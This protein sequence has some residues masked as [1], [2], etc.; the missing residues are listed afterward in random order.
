[1]ARKDT[2]TFTIRIEKTLLKSIRK[3]AERE[4]RS[5]NYIIEKILKTKFEFKKWESIYGF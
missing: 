1:M 4:D 5:P 2:I 3:E